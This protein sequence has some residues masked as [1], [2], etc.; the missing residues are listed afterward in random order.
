MTEREPKEMSVGHSDQERVVEIGA[1]GRRSSSRKG[2]V[3]IPDLASDS[4]ADLITP[5]VDARSESA[6]RRSGDIIEIDDSSE[7]S[8][9]VRNRVGLGQQLSY[10]QQHQL[11]QRM[12]QKQQE[13]R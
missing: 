13:Q 8:S 9:D 10:E 12:I 5:S 3:M 1:G 6:E 11:Q 4:G 7:R 2:S